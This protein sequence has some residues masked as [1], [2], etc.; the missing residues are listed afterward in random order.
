MAYERWQSLP[1]MFFEQAERHAAQAV[2]L[3]Q[4]GRR[5]AAVGAMARW[6]TRCAMS[7]AG[8]LALGLVPGDR[9]VL[10]AE[11][12]P[13]WPIADLAIMAAGGITVPAYTTNTVEDH[14]HILDPQRRARGHR[15]EPGARGAAAAGGDRGAERRAS[16]S[17][18]TISSSRSARR[19]RC[20]AGTS[21]MALGK[22]I[23]A[24]AVDERMRALKRDDTACFIYTSGTGGAPKGVMLSHGAILANCRGAYDVLEQLGLGDEVFLSFLPLSHSYEHTAGQIFPISIGAEIYYAEG[25]EKLADNMVEARPTIMTAVPRLYEMMHQRSSAASPRRSRLQ[26]P[27]VRA[28]AG[29]RAASATSGPAA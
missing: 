17:G 16:S 5:V 25:A 8:L 24:T 14:R 4:V 27:L 22:D 12:R 10:V 20:M 29:A 11:N 6:R 19:R 28:H 3:A 1:A 15:L 26:A 18:S 13:E 21:C 2:S 23:A 9:V 7:R